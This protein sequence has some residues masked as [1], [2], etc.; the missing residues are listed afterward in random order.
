M[1]NRQ[2]AIAV[3]KELLEGCLGLDGRTV[4]L[5]PPPIMQGGYQ[6]VIRGILAE[7]SR[8]QIQAITAKHQLA[9]Q[10]GNIW[11]TRHTLKEQ[12]DTIII[13]KPKN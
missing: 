10:T 2:E 5:E 11:K 7:K 9:I 13:Y 12:P 4:S 8:A 6:I 1:L 3:V